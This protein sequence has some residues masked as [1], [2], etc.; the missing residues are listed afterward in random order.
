VPQGRSI[1]TRVSHK[2]AQQHHHPQQHLQKNHKKKTL[3]IPINKL[4]SMKKKLK[5][6]KKKVKN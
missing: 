1:T 4:P 6:L 2:L 5:K 3:Q